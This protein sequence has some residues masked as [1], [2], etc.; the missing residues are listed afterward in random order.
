MSAG[1]PPI[2][3]KTSVDT[4]H[5]MPAAH[6]ANAPTLAAKNGV[7]QNRNTPSAG[8]YPAASGVQV[9]HAGIQKPGSSSGK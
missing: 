8:T 6:A 1:L 2:S 7:W 9:P 5:G 3:G 4:K